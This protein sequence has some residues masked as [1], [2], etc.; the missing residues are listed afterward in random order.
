MGRRQRLDF[1]QLGEMTRCDFCGRQMPS[2]SR[3]M[4]IR[5]NRVAC[6]SCNQALEIERRLGGRRKNNRKQRNRRKRQPEW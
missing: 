4:R 3:G 5:R 2:D 6:A 1:T